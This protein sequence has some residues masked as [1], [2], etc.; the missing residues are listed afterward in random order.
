MHGDR[1]KIKI[2]ILYRLERICD[3]LCVLYI[4]DN[5]Y[6]QQGTSNGHYMRFYHT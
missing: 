4:Y 2:V 6:S 3:V 1:I 5:K